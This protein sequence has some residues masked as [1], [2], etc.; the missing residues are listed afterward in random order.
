MVSGVPTSS[1]FEE[2]I[3]FSEL[4]V[5][6]SGAI[7]SGLVSSKR[8]SDD[9]IF[10]LAK[11]S[12]N[13]CSLSCQNSFSLA[14]SRKGNSRTWWTNMYRSIGSSESRGDTSPKSDLN[15]APNRRRAVGEFSSEISHL[16]CS[17]TSSRFRSACFLIS[18]KTWMSDTRHERR[19]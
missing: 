4:N 15:G 14:L 13:A 9:D 5:V 1:G 2:R 19:G 18:P 8:S 16:T 11:D 12:R 10:L 17:E 3:R 6:D 7:D